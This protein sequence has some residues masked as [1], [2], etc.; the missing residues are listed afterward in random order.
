MDRS[1]KSCRASSKWA[2]LWSPRQPAERKLPSLRPAR[3]PALP[4]PR[5]APCAE[6]SEGE[7]SEP[8]SL[9]DLHDVTKK[10][11]L[12]DVDGPALNCLTLRVDHGES[13]AIMSSSGS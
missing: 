3:P 2:M 13:V 6:S 11:H 1:P 8:S 7:M 10:Y 12:G 5:A 4:R 9:L